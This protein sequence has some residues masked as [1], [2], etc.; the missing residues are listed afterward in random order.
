MTIGSLYARWTL[1]CVVDAALGIAHDFVKRPR[2]YTELEAAD[3]AVLAKFR[4]LMGSS[5]DWPNAAQRAAMYA[6]MLGTSDAKAGDKSHLFHQTANAVRDA[7]VAYAE[8]VYDTG[9]PMLK[10]AFVDA[11]DAFKAHLDMLEG[12]ALNEAE[13]AT[14]EV[15]S[16]A[17]KVLTTQALAKAFGLPPAAGPPQQQ[18]QQQQAPAAPN[19][20]LAGAKDGKGAALIEEVTRVLQPGGGVQISQQ[21]FTTLQRV[22]QRGQEAIACALADHH[23]GNENQLN[24]LLKNS[25]AWA[26][27]LRG[28]TK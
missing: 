4:T 14:Q 15:F 25:Y 11:A 12:A 5:P 9:E 8:R 27:A 28:V 16:Q 2:H 3:V 17:V 24:A 13:R 23:N 1:D 6:S 7:A 22:A 19:W 21:Q 26:T 18:N 20:P 10:Q